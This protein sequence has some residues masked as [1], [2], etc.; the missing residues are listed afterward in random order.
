[1]QSFELLAIKQT[2]VSTFFHDFF[3]FIAISK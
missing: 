3:M 1:M 2:E